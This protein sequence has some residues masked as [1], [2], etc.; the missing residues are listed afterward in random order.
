ML[1]NLLLYVCV[2]ITRT[3]LGSFQTLTGLCFHQ[4]KAFRMI[5]I[6]ERKK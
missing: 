5:Q 6:Q 4:G 1:Y 3:R 2:Y